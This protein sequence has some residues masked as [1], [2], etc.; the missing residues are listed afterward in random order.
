MLL[1]FGFTTTIKAQRNNRLHK[2]TA[3]K[4]ILTQSKIVGGKDASVDEF[5]FFVSWDSCGASLIASDIVL[6]AAHCMPAVTN[7]VKINHSRKLFG[8]QGRGIERTIVKRIPHPSY[9]SETTN[10]DYMIMKLNSPVT[11]V[12]P[13]HLNEN[14]AVPVDNQTLTVIGFGTL[15]A[16]G[17]TPI[18]LK[19][20]TVG[21]VLTSECNL[22]SSYNGDI[23][24][25]TMFC[26]GKG[27]KD[28]CQGDSGGPIFVNYPDG[29]F[30]QVG[31]VSWGRGCANANYPGVYSRVSGKLSWIKQQV[32]DNS[33]YKP[34]Y[35][36]GGGGDVLA[37]SSTPLTLLKPT[38]PPNQVRVRLD[39]K[40]DNYPDEVSWYFQQNG[41]VLD[42]GSGK[43]VPP[44]NTLSWLTTNISSGEASFQI[45]DSGSDGVCCGHG[46]GKYTLFSENPYGDVELA[47]SNGKFG[48]IEIKSLM[49]SANPATVP[50]VST[51]PPARLPT[52]LPTRPSTGLPTSCTAAASSKA[53]YKKELASRIVG[54]KVASAGEF[55]FMVSW[56]RNFYSFPSCGGSLISPNLVLT[57]AH[58]SGI[59]GG[60]RVGSLNA[61]GL[62]NGSP[63]GVE[64]G[65]IRE[66]MHPQYNPDT[67]ANDYMILELD[68]SIDTSIY[69][70]INLNFD[71]QQP[72]P[73]EMLTVIGFGTLTAG[74]VQPDNLM[75]V[76]VP[77]V[78]HA[79][80]SCQYEGLREDI[81]L[82]A[83]YPR[84]E[85][86]SCQGDSGGPTFK[87]ING[88]T[89]QVGVVSFGKGCALPGFSGVYARLSGVSS[90]LKTNICNIS[91]EPKPSY[92]E[93][94][95]GTTLWPSSL[96]TQPPAQLPT[97]SGLAPI[98]PTAEG[99]SNIYLHNNCYQ[100]VNVAIRYMD[101]NSR[102]WKSR[103]W[104]N[105]DPSRAY[106]TTNNGQ[107]IST[108]NS[109]IYVYAKSS[110][111]TWTTGTST[112][113]NIRR[114]CDG[115]YLSMFAWDYRDTDNDFNVE[116][117]CDLDGKNDKAF[118][119]NLASGRVGIDDE[120]E[121]GGDF[122]N[123]S[124]DNWY[125]DNDGDEN[126]VYH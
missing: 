5:P 49:I 122:Q 31:I 114:I 12:E 99:G 93:G 66:I 82:C 55:P 2:T 41:T 80:C 88:V 63:T 83:G 96:S 9:D 30:S 44:G 106:F 71:S 29:T 70:P 117:T 35:C 27:G 69:T 28:S 101:P 89:T 32:C 10:N 1:S 39:I 22:A 20:V 53:K 19:K 17:G 103:C 24:D 125:E 18:N 61:K 119:M 21:Y 57:A 4:H 94:F 64:T 65:V 58:C 123:E 48:A 72:A 78:S 112:H 25:G 124:N 52:Q 92:C 104:Y 33:D 102:V 108:N 7:S 50:Q 118:T 116:F 59:S 14:D 34:D 3:V 16:G 90:W 110:T 46:F 42:S 98:G 74:G 85:K 8:F 87:E 36:R 67:T 100:K 73:G 54:G 11:E 56:H 43:H 115:T 37:P 76:N 113:P 95:E 40:F 91:S 38:L 60:V 120:V 121:D 47:S 6:T 109:V 13:I 111:V 45:N 86:D 105:L 23:Q 97:T 126:L 77:V 15:Y 75:K 84:G 107:R 68:Q 51:R 79:I 62:Y 81:Q 26:A